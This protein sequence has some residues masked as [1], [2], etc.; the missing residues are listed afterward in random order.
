MF[1]YCSFLLSSVIA[2]RD[3]T[4]LFQEIA[5]RAMLFTRKGYALVRVYYKVL[6]LPLILLTITWR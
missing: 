1:N 3:L 5:S 2:N 4:Q 6:F